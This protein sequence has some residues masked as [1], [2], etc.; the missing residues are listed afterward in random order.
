V[1]VLTDADNLDDITTNGTYRW[2][3]PAPAGSPIQ[4]YC[5]MFVQHDGGQAIQMAW[6]SSQT[7]S[8][9]AIRRKTS[10][11][12]NEWVHFVGAVGGVT[13]EFRLGDDAR[14]ASVAGA[15]ALRF[16]AGTLQASDGGS[17]E[18]VHS[19]GLSEVPCSSLGYQ[20][21]G[22]T[23]DVC[24]NVVGT[25]GDTNG[26]AQGNI[27][28]S[29]FKNYCEVSGG[30]LCTK[31]EVLAGEVKGTGC[32]HDYRGIWTSTPG[33]NPGE[34]WVVQGDAEGGVGHTQSVLST[35]SSGLV[36]FVTNE[37]GVR[38]C[39]DNY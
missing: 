2:T 9:L 10:G 13:T 18:N 39:G 17:W 7:N 36:G 23:T 21:I 34:Y 15:G 22:G 4:A 30:R 12:W 19:T 24:G 6:G 11:S 31:D 37:F 27:T 5:N 29:Q 35:S 8:Q 38:C 26:C 1:Q 3:S 28:W 14:T 25:S 33:S 16:N 32:S 20:E